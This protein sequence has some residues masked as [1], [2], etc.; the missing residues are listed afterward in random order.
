M[1]A[2]QLAYVGAIGL[3]VLTS[4]PRAD[5][6]DIAATSFDQMRLLVRLGDVVTVTDASGHQVK[7]RLAGLTDTSLSLVGD[8]RMFAQG[9]VEA[10]S[11]HDHAHARTGALWGF[12]V[13]AGL[14]ILVGQSFCQYSCNP[15]AYAAGALLYGGLGAGIGVGISA[16]IPTEQLV[17][18]SRS[19]TARLTVAPVVSPT[20]QALAVSLRF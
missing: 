4:S 16:M 15:A 10:V 18:R 1:K 5:A 8:N 17:F 12:G 9:E 2:A 20:S 14:G 19:S 3:L 13:G 11:R 6:Q 7:G